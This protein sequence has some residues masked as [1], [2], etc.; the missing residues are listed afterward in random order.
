MHRSFLPHEAEAASAGRIGHRRIR[1]LDEK[2][3]PA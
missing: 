3:V 2:I 1:R